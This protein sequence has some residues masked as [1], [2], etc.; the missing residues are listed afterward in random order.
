M[1]EPEN[2]VLPTLARL[3]PTIDPM[4]DDDIEAV[5][6]LFGIV[7]A[8]IPYYNDLAKAAER[9]KYDLQS[10][11]EI[12]RDRSGDILVAKT[13]N[14]VIG[15]CILKDDDGLKWLSWYGVHPSFRRMGVSKLLLHG[16]D[17]LTKEHG[18]H[19]IWCDTIAANRESAHILETSGYNRLCELKNHW[20]GQDYILWEKVLP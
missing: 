17:R 2:D 19:K 8:A 16:V 18:A 13:D 14:A 6:A 4:H 7:L 15:F 5:H 20:F 10:L 3:S 9:G 12:L 11:I 1:T